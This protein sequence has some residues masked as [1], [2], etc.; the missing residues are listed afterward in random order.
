MDL[1]AIASELSHAGRDVAGRAA[2]ALGVAVAFLRTQPLLLSAALLTAALVIAIVLVVTRG[3]RRTGTVARHRAPTL[4]RS[5]AAEGV[6]ADEIARR[7]G[8]ARDAVALLTTSAARSAGR[9]GRPGTASFAANGS[10]RGPRRRAM[11][12]A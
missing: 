1:T 11:A 8:L 6:P 4:A 5:L 10:A 2:D 9:K 3:R 7:T 12:H